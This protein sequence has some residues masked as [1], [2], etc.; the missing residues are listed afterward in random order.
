MVHGDAFNSEPV[1]EVKR[2]AKSIPIFRLP[3]HLGQAHVG[4]FKIDER[5]RHQSRAFQT[6]GD[7]IRFW[8]REQQSGERGSVYDL[9][10]GHGRPARWQPSQPAYGG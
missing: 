9:C 10:V 7:A 5:W 2:G 4:Q 3:P 6:L 1:Q 8:L